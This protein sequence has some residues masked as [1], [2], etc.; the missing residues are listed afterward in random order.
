MKNTNNTKTN[1]NTN[2]NTKKTNNEL[3]NELINS[4][5]LHFRNNLDVVTKDNKKLFQ[6]RN[7]EKSCNMYLTLKEYEMLKTL[8]LNKEA[9]KVEHIENVKNPYI[10][11]NNV[12][13]NYLK[14]SFERVLKNK[15]L[16]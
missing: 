6:V 12:S 11:I 16:E 3:V 1:N 14:Q 13:I 8:K 5:N 4:K 2:N 15:G 10:A 9:K 7:N